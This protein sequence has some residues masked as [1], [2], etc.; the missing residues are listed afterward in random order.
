[1]AVLLR[2]E[3][4]RTGNA[5]FHP[6]MRALHTPRFLQVELIQCFSEV[7]ALLLLAD[8]MLWD[9]ATFH[10]WIGKWDTPSL[11]QVLIQC[12]SEVTP[13]QLCGSNCFRQCE[14]FRLYFI[15]GLSR[16]V[17]PNS[18]H[19]KKTSATCSPCC[20]RHLTPVVHGLCSMYIVYIS[21]HIISNILH[22]Y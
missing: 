1:M 2:A 6:W 19:M 20:S 18:Y 10:L 15:S 21:L 13:G 7:M 17:E 12:F 4:L 22:L 8:A 5:T 3:I 9:D 11:P 14:Q 16:N